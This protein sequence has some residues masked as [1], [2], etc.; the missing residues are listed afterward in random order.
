MNPIK[1]V[2][3]VGGGTAGLIAALYFK[4]YFPQFNVKVVK[5]SSVGIIG[6]GEGTT[7]Q[8]NYFVNELEIDHLELLNKTK[9]PGLGLYT[10]DD[11]ASVI[12]SLSFSFNLVIIAP[13][14]GS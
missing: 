1:D 8:F 5:S 7:E 4:K 2:V 10:I 13:G 14:L 3:I 6:V 12:L 11:T 9:S